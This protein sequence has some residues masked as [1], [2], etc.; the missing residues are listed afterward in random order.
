MNELFDKQVNAQ[1]KLSGSRKLPQA[2]EKGC[3]ENE[4]KKQEK[5]DGHLNY[6]LMEGRS[7]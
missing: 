5:N 3:N 7:L 2:H 6:F 1:K 4:I